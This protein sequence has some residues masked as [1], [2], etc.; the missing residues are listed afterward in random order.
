MFLSLTMEMDT[1]SFLLISASPTGWRAG[2][3]HKGEDGHRRK[4]FSV[5]A[6]G[7]DKANE[8][9]WGCPRGAAL[10]RT[11][12]LQQS[13]LLRLWEHYPHPVKD[14][15]WVPEIKLYHYASFSHFTVGGN[16]TPQKNKQKTFPKE[17][18]RQEGLYPVPNSSQNY[19][20][21]FN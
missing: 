18:P 17:T 7:R 12:L 9:A 21:G 20:A 15:Q 16:K 3:V 11:A 4:R 1:S 8:R 2:H 13:L 10:E 19:Q 14:R 6:V 5:W